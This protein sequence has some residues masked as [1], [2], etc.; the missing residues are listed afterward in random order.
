[1][2][3]SDHPHLSRQELRNH[4]EWEDKANWRLG[5][6]YHS[7]RDSRSW[8][9]K[10]SHF[11]RKRFGGTPNFGQPSARSHLMLI[12]GGA[13]LVVLVVVLLERAGVLR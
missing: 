9:P 11:G 5:I 3:D 6:F 13:L 10:R 2:E 12:F 4:A 7:E 8:V 1:M